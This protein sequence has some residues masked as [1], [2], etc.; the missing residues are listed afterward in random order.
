MND[1][2]LVLLSIATTRAT[3]NLNSQKPKIE[4]TIHNSF[5]TFQIL[6]V[7]EASKRILKFE[8]IILRQMSNN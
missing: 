3:I 4:A 5:L 8:L 6:N 2:D 1:K 7:D